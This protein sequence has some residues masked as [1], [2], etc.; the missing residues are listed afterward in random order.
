MPRTRARSCWRRFSLRGTGLPTIARES[1]GARRP[2]SM[3]SWSRSRRMSGTIH[4]TTLYKDYAVSPELFHWESQSTTTTTSTA[5]R[6]YLTGASS[7]VLFTRQAAEDDR[8][9]TTQYTCLGTARYVSHS[10]EKPIAITWK[11][12]RPMPA[13]VF[14]VAN[15]VA[16]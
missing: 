3:R 2:G 15:A 8:G 11:L 14:A 5:G 12:Q 10:G 6:R 4:R 13:D 1:P 7:V 9:M 16:V